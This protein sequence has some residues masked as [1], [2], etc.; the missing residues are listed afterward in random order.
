VVERK[1]RKILPHQRKRTLDGSF[2]VNGVNST[3]TIRKLKS[4]N[5]IP[6][7]EIEKEMKGRQETDRYLG[8][9]ERLLDILAEDNEFVLSRGLTHQQ[10]AEPLFQIANEHLKLDSRFYTLR[11][12]INGVEFEVQGSGFPMYEY[13]PFRDGGIQGHNYKVTNIRTGKSLH[14]SAIHPYLISR[15]GFYEGKQ[16]DYRIN[17]KDIIGVFALGKSKHQENSGSSAP[18]AQ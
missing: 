11:M 8:P 4:L 16:V 10:L 15:Y 7:E 13:S 6:I 18:N 17:P 1:P 5:G 9:N 2:E 14:F 12:S 3:E